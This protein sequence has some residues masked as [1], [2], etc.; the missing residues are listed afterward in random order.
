MLMFPAYDCNAAQALDSG[1]K[2]GAPVDAVADIA[3]RYVSVQEQSEKTWREVRTVSQ[4]H[5]VNWEWLDEDE[6]AVR[7]T[8]AAKQLSEHIAPGASLT[9]WLY[10]QEKTLLTLKSS[11]SYGPRKAG[12]GYEAI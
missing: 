10:W 3:K 6:V 2:F 7:F 8:G 12:R 5:G 11:F 9:G 4:R 1:L